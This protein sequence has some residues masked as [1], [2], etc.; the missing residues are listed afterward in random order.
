M[1]DE[2][3]ITTGDLLKRILRSWVHRRWTIAFTTVGIA[4]ATIAGTLYLPN[5]Y[6]SEA[7][8]F[9]VQQRVPERYVTPTMSADPSQALEAMVQE[10]LSRPRLLEVIDE[11]GLYGERVGLRTDELIDLIREDLTVEPLERKL[12]AGTV[13][14]FR[15]TFIAKSPELA[16]AVTKKLTNLFIA[17]NLK[18]RTDQAE[19]TTEFLSEQ[20]ENTRAELLTQEQHLRDYKMQYLGQLPEQQAGN[21]G[22]LGSLQSQLNSVMASR[23]QAQQQRLYLDSLLSEYQNRGNRASVLRSSTGEMVVPV[24]LAERELLRLQTERQTLLSTYTA[25]HPDVVKKEQEIEFQ[26]E[27]LKQLRAGRSDMARRDPDSGGAELDSESSMMIAQLTSQ[28][29]ANKLELD[30]LAEKE[31]KIHRDINVYQGRLNMT[32]V[33]EQQL[34][35]MQR[36]YDLLKTHYGDLLKKEQE[37]QLAKDLEKRQEGQQFRLA[38]PPNLP[39]V[40]SSP[41]RLKISL[42]GLLLGLTFGCGLAFLRELSAPSI[43]TEE[44]ARQFELPMV[45]GIPNLLTPIEVRKRSWMRALE[46]CAAFM[47]AAVVALAEFYVYLQG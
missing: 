13:N 2:D 9:A 16:H 27:V 28:L 35:S 18:T 40:P 7:T 23:S 30:N 32:P 3:R 38:E 22:I 36:D 15:I 11:L 43:H 5:K 17:Q 12:G 44:D 37:S 42:V 46:C 34:T 25:R 26:R 29:R 20:L 24:Q 8:L 4:L 19:T 33:R 31:Q 47:L 10:V 45:V 21:L 39:T 1:N 41:N 14:A 6:T